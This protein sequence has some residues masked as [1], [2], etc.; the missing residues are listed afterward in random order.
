L[1][2]L[3]PW[4]NFFSGVATLLPSLGTKRGM[5]KQGAAQELSGRLSSEGLYGRWAPLY[6]LIFDLPFHPG[7]LA[8][9][10]ATAAA[11][12]A[13]G[14]VLVVGVGTGLELGLLPKGLRVTGVDI[15]VRMLTLARERVARRSLSQ[16]KALQVMDA[17]A[18]E[19]PDA[20]FDVAVAPYVM[21]VV[22]SPPRALDEMWR[23]LKPGGH[24]VI[25]NHFSAE[26]GLRARIEGAMEKSA[27]WLG[28]HP[29]FPYAA[30][31]DWLAARKDAALVESRLIAPFRLFTLLKI[32]K[33]P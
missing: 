10:G 25:V 27:S 26:T 22:P 12:G 6:D 16:V 24:I 17:A 7:R 15:S 20:R 29:V 8:V 14:E 33:S 23:V 32:R 19:F 18:L 2:A 4:A 9:A 1:Q 21:S 11:A 13:T 5:A 3:A 30:V 28:W 31:G